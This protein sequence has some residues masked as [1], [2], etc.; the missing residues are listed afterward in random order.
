MV[1]QSK[2][3]PL[4]PPIGG[5][6]VLVTL[7]VLASACQRTTLRPFPLAPPMLEDADRQHVEVMPEPYFSGLVWDL[8]DQTF[9]RSFNRYLTV[10]VTEPSVNVNA[11]DEVPNSSWFENRLGTHELSEQALATGACP[12]TLLRADAGPWLVTDAKPNGANPGFIIRDPEGRGWLLKFDGIDQGERATAAD[13][14]GSRIYHAAG[15]HAPCNIIVEFD[16]SVLQ[17]ADDAE[18]EDERGEDVPMEQHHVQQVLDSAFVLPDGR[19]RASAS[20]F[21]PGR[22]LG[23]WRYQGTW[24]EDPNDVIPHEDRRELRGAR[25]LAAWLNHFDAREQNTLAIWYTEEDGTAYVKHYYLDFGDCLG[26]RWDQDG[27]SRRFGNA[28]YFDA[29]EILLDLFSFGLAL[30]PWDTV[31]VNEQAHELGYFDVEHFDPVR[32]KVGYPNP[33]FVRMQ[34]E[35]GAWMARIIAAFDGPRVRA[36]LDEARIV[37]ADFDAEVMR[38]LM[39]RRRLILE[40]WL[41]VRSPL[42]APRVEGDGTT[43]CVDDLAVQTGVLPDDEV[44]YTARLFDGGSWR[45]PRWTATLAPGT[46]GQLCIPLTRSASPRPSDVD[47]GREVPE[48]YAVLDLVVVPHAGADPVPPLRVHLVDEGTSGFTVVG[49]ER[50]ADD[51]PPGGGR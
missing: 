27:L 10:D 32:W 33:S 20:L 42:D 2:Q 43:L 41:L 1:Q 5:L 25:L 36:M 13:V 39:A 8:V 24:R 34:A 4:R 6:L 21:L 37:D 16:P 29:A 50:P 3:G 44:R 38:V 15:Y 31:T 40:H 30:R 47:S 26:S 9:F 46:G 17:I 12:D 14:F 35:D 48:G 18:A 7:G 49:I 19:L 22:P 11:W 51:A 28:Y 23:P 45:R